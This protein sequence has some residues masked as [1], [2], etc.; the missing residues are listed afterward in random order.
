MSN[1][2]NCPPCDTE[3]PLFC[4]GLETT[5]DGRKIVVEDNASCQKVL[6]EPTEVSVLQYDQNNDVAWKSGS[7]VSPIKLPSLQ[8]NAVNVAPKIMVL[9]VDGTVR[10]WQPTDTGDNFLAYWDGTQWKIG[11][12]ASL[13]PAGNGVLVKTGSSFSLA[14]GVNGDFLQVSS[15]SIQFNS[16]IPGGIPTGTVVPYAANSAPSGWVICDGSLYG[17]TALDPSPQPNLFGVIGTTYGIGDGLTT[18]AI[19]DLRGMFV[20]GFDNG[21]GLDPL[22]VF[23]T[24]QSF[25]VESHNHSGTTGNQSVGHTHPFSGTTVSA[26]SHTH[27]QN[28]LTGTGGTANALAVSNLINN[29]INSTRISIN[30]AGAHTHTFS[31]TTGSVSADHTHSIPS[32]GQTETR[33]VNVAMNYIIKT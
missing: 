14:N 29:E 12:L 5:T 24:D 9:Q 25:A 7:L 26:G 17:R 23:G 21:R 28:I 13:L 22:R 19:P 33:P 1:C 32:Y 8:L 6:L 31:G 11:N 2:T 3:F 15:G 20:R 27:T 16:T 4:E 10:Q 30:A 18:F